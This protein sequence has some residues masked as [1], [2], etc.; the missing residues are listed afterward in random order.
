M[1]NLCQRFNLKYFTNDSY[2]NEDFYALMMMM[3]EIVTVRM[4]SIT[5]FITEKYK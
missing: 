5:L 4:L 1:R 3:V 2:P